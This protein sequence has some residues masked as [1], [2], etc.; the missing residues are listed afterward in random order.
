[1]EELKLFIKESE[2]ITPYSTEDTDI[3]SQFLTIDATKLFDNI[4][5]HINE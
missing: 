5:V 2:K 3:I 4:I 1:M